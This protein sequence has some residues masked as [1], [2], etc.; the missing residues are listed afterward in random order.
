[1]SRVKSIPITE[2]GRK[3]GESKGAPTCLELGLKCLYGIEKVVL[4]F[5][6]EDKD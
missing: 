2:G 6:P 4:L 3:E 1:M 5:R